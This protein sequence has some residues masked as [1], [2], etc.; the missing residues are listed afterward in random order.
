MTTLP[1]KI[2]GKLKDIRL[3]LLDVDGVL[4]DGRIGLLPGGEEIKFFSIY[5]GLAIR[6]E[7]LEGHEATRAVVFDRDDLPIVIRDSIEVR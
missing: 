1:D 3:I 4:T 6:L 2:V 7:T 5:D